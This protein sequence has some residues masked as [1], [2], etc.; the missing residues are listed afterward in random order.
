[1]YLVARKSQKNIFAL[2]AA[3]LAHVLRHAEPDWEAL[4]GKSLFITGGTGF[5][6]KWLLG[7][8]L[9][10][11]AE[12]DLGLSLTVLSRNPISF[13]EQFPEA[14]TYPALHFL[15]G[16]VAEFLPTKD[17]FDYILHAAT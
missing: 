2:P 16:H 6:G 15:E 11:N 13:L 1:T 17:H 8:L 14:A 7:S 5:F 4:R 10:A 12:L 3:D 9:H